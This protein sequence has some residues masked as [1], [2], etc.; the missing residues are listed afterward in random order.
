MGEFLFDRWLLKE[1]CLDGNKNGLVTNVPIKG[2]LQRNLCIVRNALSALISSQDDYEIVAAFLPN[3]VSEMLEN[4]RGQAR[5][6]LATYINSEVEDKTLLDSSEVL[7][8]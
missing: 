6:F 1:F 4:R 2:A 8:A 7:S 3:Q 5:R